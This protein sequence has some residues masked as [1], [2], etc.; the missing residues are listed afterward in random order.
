[1]PDSGG[2]S[3]ADDAAVRQIQQSRARESGGAIFN[4]VSD[5]WAGE[6]MVEANMEPI[7]CIVIN[8]MS[9]E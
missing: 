8:N 4:S 7:H 5:P 6:A 3:D 9:R 1:M 2:R